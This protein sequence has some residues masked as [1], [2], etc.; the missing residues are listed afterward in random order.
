MTTST[1]PTG[2]ALDSAWHAERDRLDRLT[3]LY[4]QVDTRF[5]DPIAGPNLQVVRADVTATGNVLPLRRIARPSTGLSFPIGIDIDAAGNLYVSNQY[6][7]I[8]ELSFPANGDRTPLASIE[9]SATGLS[10]PGHL[11]VAPPL[12]VATKALPPA[13]GRHP[14]LHRERQGRLP[15]PDARLAAPDHR[16]PTITAKGPGALN[17]RRHRPPAEVSVLPRLQIIGQ[18][19][20]ER[21]DRERGVD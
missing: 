17:R 3:S 9:G 16:R 18:P 5:L 20:G 15:P 7:G 21:H 14:P 1:L 8:E 10:A 13:Q 11:A 12:S 6:A 2:Y 4:D 19:T